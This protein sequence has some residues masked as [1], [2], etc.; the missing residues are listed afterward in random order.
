MEAAWLDDDGSFRVNRDDR[1]VQRWT[2][3]ATIKLDHDE[4]HE[5]PR[6]NAF[7]RPLFSKLALQS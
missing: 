3:Y 4:C 1:Q 7:P 5:G 6:S 2:V